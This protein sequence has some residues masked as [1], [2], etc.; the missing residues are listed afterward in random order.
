MWWAGE[1]TGL[2]GINWWVAAIQAQ[3][4]LSIGNMITGNLMECQAC[5]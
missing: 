3:N 2:A 5:I 1:V 4:A